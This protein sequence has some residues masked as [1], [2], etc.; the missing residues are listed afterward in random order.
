MKQYEVPYNFAYDFVPKLARKSELFKFIRCVYL[1]AWKEDST[2]TRQDI[3]SREEYP[4]SYD[5]YQI[6]LKGLQQLGLP[7]CILMQ[8][9]A[10]LES[11]EKYYDLGVRIFTINDD[12]L[13]S[14]AKSRH[15]DISLTLSV[16]RAL[17]EAGI[18]N[19]DFSMYDNIVLFF[20]FTRHL[21]V[22]KTLPEKYHYILMPN[23]ECYWNC[24][25]H[26]EHWF[27]TTREEEIAA[28]SNC[29]KCIMGTHDTSLIEAEN[30]SYFDPYV[31]AYKL[32]DRLDTTNRIISNLELYAYRNIGAQ[33]RDESYFNIE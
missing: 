19:G 23:T 15:P 6:R 9:N 18:R 12:R 33:K 7:V 1:P 22:L 11:L 2:S 32:V 4:K 16:T 3:Q 25:W 5:E 24:H 20:W 8:K 30:L 28:T 13:A 26:D 10:S 27:A 29:H 17:T 14:D 21:D 31:D